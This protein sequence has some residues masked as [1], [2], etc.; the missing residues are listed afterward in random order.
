MANCFVKLKKEVREF[1]KGHSSAINSIVN[2]SQSKVVKVLKSHSE[3]VILFDHSE[4]SKA[5][6]QDLLHASNVSTTAA[7]ATETPK[8]KKSTRKDSKDRKTAT[9]KTH[10]PPATHK[11]DAAASPAADVKAN[12]D[13]KATADVKAEIIDD[14]AD[15]TTDVKADEI[16]GGDDGAAVEDEEEEEDEAG[17]EEEE[18]EAGKEEEEDEA[19]H[20][21]YH[22]VLTS[23]R[24]P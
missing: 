23:F 21:L 16:T 6:L 14:K 5:K 3:L 13:D 15:E 18:D 8:K 22:S 7:S 10:L 24:L 1:Y 2:E 11:G 9:P 4:E 20:H 19:N 17:K 12:A